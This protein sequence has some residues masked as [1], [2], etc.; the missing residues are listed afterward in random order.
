ML[1]CLSGS[2]SIKSSSLAINDIDLQEN[3]TKLKGALTKT[4]R[5]LISQ[6]QKNKNYVYI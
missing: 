3:L 4:F 5:Y 6:H 2:R 1:I